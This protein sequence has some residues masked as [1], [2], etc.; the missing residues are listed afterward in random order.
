MSTELASLSDAPRVGHGPA[1][2]R[3]LDGHGVAPV[4]GLVGR[5]AEGAPRAL[6]RKEP[7]G[8]REELERRNL[9]AWPSSSPRGRRRRRRAA[10]TRRSIAFGGWLRSAGRPWS[11]ISTAT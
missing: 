8:V 7:A 2:E 10:T 1:L 9:F 6:A 11:G 3:S 4:D 5:D